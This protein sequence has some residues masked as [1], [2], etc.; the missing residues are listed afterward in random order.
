M[1]L[2][3]PH[4]K[5]QKIPRASGPSPSHGNAYLDSTT[6]PMCNKYSAFSFLFLF[7]SYSAVLKSFAA[8]LT[9]MLSDFRFSDEFSHTF[10][11]RY[12]FLTSLAFPKEI[13]GMGLLCSSW[14]FMQ[15]RLHQP[16]EAIKK[17]KDKTVKEEGKKWKNI[18]I[19]G[20]SVGLVPQWNLSAYVTILPPSPVILWI[21]LGGKP[22]WLPLNFGYH[23][24]MCTG[25]INYNDV[26]WAK[27]D[28]PF[29]CI[30]SFPAHIA[31]F[32]W[33]IFLH[34][35]YRAIKQLQTNFFLQIKH[36]P[37]LLRRRCE[38]TAESNEQK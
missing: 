4:C 16:Y 19:N 34:V 1:L 13:F 5:L 26:P 28:H 33:L 31:F 36:F 8:C 6:S 10:E 12:N 35:F 23:D 3:L 25:P 27:K 14:C 7:S 30:A 32:H 24:V 38:L 9:S 22:K 11:N 2:V 29:R 18:E 20:F 17:K 15:R 21:E 37:F